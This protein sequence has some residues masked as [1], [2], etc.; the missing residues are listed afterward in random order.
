LLFTTSSYSDEV[1]FIAAIQLVCC[2][3]ALSAYRHS[4]HT[5]AS[6]FTDT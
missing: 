1:F 6:P 3:L 4:L 5:L 2:P